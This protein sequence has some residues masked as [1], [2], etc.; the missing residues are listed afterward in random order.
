MIINGFDE[1]TAG[2][3]K[4]GRATGDECFVV[5][6]SHWRPVPGFARTFKFYKGRAFKHYPREGHLQV[7]TDAAK[8]YDLQWQ[9][10][11][12]RWETGV[13]ILDRS[14]RLVIAETMADQQYLEE[15]VKKTLC[16]YPQE[17]APALSARALS[18]A[19]TPP[20]DDAKPRHFGLFSP[21]EDFEE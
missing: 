18:I 2:H 1:L 5:I 13:S 6:G 4:K 9:H 16:A 21:P 12:F 3:D 15:Q 19:E 20:P 10:L 14:A 8:V 11:S 17:L 7:Q